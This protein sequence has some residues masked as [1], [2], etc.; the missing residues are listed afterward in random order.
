MLNITFIKKRIK[1]IVLVPILA[2]GA[3][4]RLYGLEIQSFWNDE[5]F[6]WSYSNYDSLIEVI[7]KSARPD[8]HP[9]GY[10]IFLYFVERY[11]GDSEAV[12]RFPSAIAG[13]FSILAIFLIGQKLYSYREGLIAASFMAI[14]WCPI[15]YSQEARANSML[16]LFTLLAAY[17]WIDIV[18]N[19]NTGKKVSYY[20]ILA[21]ITTA[22]IASYLHYYGVYFIVLQGLLATLVL[23]RR[24]WALVYLFAIYALILL[25]YVPWIPTMVSQLSTSVLADWITAPKLTAFYSYIKFLF[26]RSNKLLLIVLPLYGFLFLINFYRY[27]KTKV[28]QIAPLMASPTL[29]LTLWLI[30]PFAIAFF[31]SI[32]YKPILLNRNLIISLP[33]AY[34]LLARAITQL[35]ISR[36]GQTLV[37]FSITGFFLYHLLF[38]LNYYSRPY[39]EQFREAV[40]FVVSEKL[41]YEDSVVIGYVM[42]PALLNYYFKK[43]GSEQRVAVIAGQKEDISIVS[44]YIQI[45]NPNFIWYISGHIEPSPEFIEFLD[46]HFTRINHMPFKKANVWL[47]EN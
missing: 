14:L 1:I 2:L 42:D 16:L 31:I 45:E 4:L 20:V 17:F 36:T 12:L 33:A 41:H 24:R 38:G 43:K 47:F 32:T 27:R 18:I 5:L 29:L 10:H 44:E 35:P 39:K 30:V 37:T 3:L 19:L 28:N 7:D 8:V 21:Y 6:S 40:G 23:L 26:N 25:A 13:I 46:Q 15:Y 34:L 11:I 22:I 9:P